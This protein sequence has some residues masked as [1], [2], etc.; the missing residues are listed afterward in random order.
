M[1]CF[2][3]ITMHLGFACVLKGRAIQK[4]GFSFKLQ[5]TVTVIKIL[6]HSSILDC[7]EVAMQQSSI[8]RQH[9]GSIRASTGY[10]ILPTKHSAEIGASLRPMASSLIQKYYILPRALED[11]ALACEDHYVHFAK[12]TGVFALLS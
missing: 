8:Y 7:V 6:K 1:R 3:I 2:Y 12:P 10:F 11:K 9:L 4:A 5:C